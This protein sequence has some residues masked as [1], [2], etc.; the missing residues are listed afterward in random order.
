MTSKGPSPTATIGA[1]YTTGEPT[2][3]INGEYFA[4]PTAPGAAAAGGNPVGPGLN[5]RVGEKSGIP[6]KF[7]TASLLNLPDV[8]PSVTCWTHSGQPMGKVDSFAA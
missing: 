2:T 3:C 4:S 5:T 1:L 6:W 8:F 7:T